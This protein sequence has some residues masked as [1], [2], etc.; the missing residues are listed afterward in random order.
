[1]SVLFIVKD[2]GVITEPTAIEAETDSKW[3]AF[4]LEQLLTNAAKYTNKGGVRIHGRGRSLHISDSGIGIRKEDLERIFEKGFTGYNGRLD[5]NASGIGLYLAKKVADAMSIEI[6]VE[7][8]VGK[9]TTVTLKFPELANSA[10][11]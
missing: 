7:S 5:K 10:N 1:A 2:L 9:G 4:I 3:L 8:E 11:S 6:F